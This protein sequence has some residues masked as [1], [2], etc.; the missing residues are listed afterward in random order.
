[1]RWHCPPDTG[2]ENVQQC[3]KQWHNVFISNVHLTGHVPPHAFLCR[4]HLPSK[5]ETLTQCY[6]NVGPPS[7]RLGSSSSTNIRST[8]RA[9]WTWWLCMHPSTHPLL[10]TGSEKP[11][12]QLSNQPIVFSVER[13]ND[14]LTH[15]VCNCAISVPAP[16]VLSPPPPPDP[17]AGW[18][19]ASVMATTGVIVWQ[20]R[21]RCVF[22]ALQNQKAIAAYCTAI[23]I[24]TATGSVLSYKLRYIVGFW[25]DEM[26]IS[27]NQKPTIYRNL[28]EN[29]ATGEHCSERRILQKGITWQ[30]IYGSCLAC[31]RGQPVINIL[32]APGGATSASDTSHSVVK[33]E[34]SWI[35]VSKL[36]C[37]FLFFLACVS[38]SWYL[39]TDKK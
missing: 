38:V 9:C 28:Y 11:R 31:K 14:S 19:G 30:I 34:K 32:I 18:V 7:S 39:D 35:S 22:F 10:W 8:L 4:R 25:L 3:R 24:C 36:Q 37:I 17:G 33:C 23:W 29:T 6:F 2:F 1:M 5:H 15:Q 20:R 21:A 13:A 26:A 27:T 12:M 16:G